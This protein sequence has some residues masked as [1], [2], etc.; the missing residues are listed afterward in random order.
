M[1]SFFVIALLLVNPFAF[2]Q[3]P[4]QK[5]KFTLTDQ[6]KKNFVL[7]VDQNKVTKSRDTTV[8]WGDKKC[9]YV[10]AQV[11]LS[12]LSGDTLKYLNMTCSTYDIFTSSNK[13]I[14][15]GQWPCES[16]F[17]VVYKIAPH[18]SYIFKFPLFLSGKPHDNDKIKIGI[19]LC[20]YSKTKDNETFAYYLFKHP[21]LPEN[22]LIW[23]NEVTIPK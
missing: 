16:N 17:P 14:F 11:K 22:I 3:L 10:V 1:K 15:I 20:K 4:A 18:K 7:R 13:T 5:T 23:S 9:S 19:Y 8:F 6:D 2:C 12:N 21:H